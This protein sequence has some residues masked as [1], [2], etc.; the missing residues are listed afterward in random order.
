VWREGRRG[1]HVVMGQG[2][3]SD[4]RKVG[5]GVKQMAAVAVVCSEGSDAWGGRVLIAARRWMR[6]RC[7]GDWRGPIRSDKAQDGYRGDGMCLTARMMTDGVRW[8][9]IRFGGIVQ[10]AWQ[11]GRAA[12]GSDGIR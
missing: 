11:P 7:D 4:E 12:M 10:Q 6:M 1:L 3:R 5:V 2:M 9:P 8:G